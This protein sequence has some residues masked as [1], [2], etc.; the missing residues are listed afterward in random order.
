MPLT[1]SGYSAL[2][3]PTIVED[4]Q[5]SLRDNVN[6]NLDLSST[7]VIG[8]INSIQAAAI[9]LLYAQLQAV[10]DAG[11][12]D[13]A[14]G[15]NLDDL[16]ALIG[17]SRIQASPST[18]RVVIGG[19]VGITV[20]RNTVFG[21]ANSDNDYYLISDRQ[22]LPSACVY[23]EVFI[24]EVLPSTAY[25][26][27]VNGTTYTYT[28]TSSPSVASIIQGL[29]GVLT[30]SSDT[31]FAV[32]NKANTSLE[33]YSSDYNTY[34]LQV[35][36]STL[37]AFD[38]VKVVGEIVSQELG[39]ASVPTG[40]IR[41]IRTPVLGLRSVTNPS[42][43]QAGRGVETDEQ[44]RIR[45]SESV[46]IAGKATAPAIEAALK[47]IE[48]V[49]LAKVFENISIYSDVSGRPAKSFEAVV[50]G[51][52]ESDVANTIW[53]TKPAGIET[54]GNTT[55]IVTDAGGNPQAVKFSRPVNQYIHA[56]VTYT[57]YD[58]E[59]FPADGE[60]TI[61]QA[62]AT[63]GNSLGVGVDVIAKRFYGGVYS[64]VAGIEDL[65]IT[66]G[67]T[68]EPDQTPSSY[69]TII[70]I[71]EVQVSNFATDRISVNVIP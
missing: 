67:L 21:D 31:T 69:T 49:T 27:N 5:Q 48:G 2:R 39:V 71:G 15:K 32:T 68:E 30:A 7:S 10:Y 43:T 66:F 9:A 55:S 34:T 62:I 25:A 35:L 63:Y 46:Q 28:S 42:A 50:L 54:Y 64:S 24:S 8:E 58:E 51:G 45:M 18:G 59:S 57:L 22:L 56:I 1:S 38:T 13:K 60:S 19:S 20:P 61:K 26:I 37:I 53:D 44:L 23:C 47:N 6:P 33:I 70:P 65:N 36:P 41:E 40:S 52:T 14:E 3:F 11:N 16:A 29:E 12:R 4:I 17:V